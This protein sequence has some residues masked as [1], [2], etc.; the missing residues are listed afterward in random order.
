MLTAN[1]I[2]T[3]KNAAYRY[4]H[5]NAY[6]DFKVRP[7]GDSLGYILEAID[8]IQNHA[9]GFPLYFPVTCKVQDTLVIGGQPISAEDALKY[10]AQPGQGALS[11]KEDEYIKGGRTFPISLKFAP[12]AWLIGDFE[13]EVYKPVLSYSCSAY[14]R[15]AMATQ[16]TTIEGLKIVGKKSLANVS[17]A[18]NKQIGLLMTGGNNVHLTNCHFF[19]LDE[20]FVQN[21]TYHTQMTLMRFINCGRGYLSLGAE[22]SVGVNFLSDHCNIGYE[23]K[24]GVG[25]WL[26]VHTEQCPKGVII[27]ASVNGFIGMYLEQLDKTSGENDYQLQI[28]YESGGDV[29]NLSITAM[30]IAGEKGILMNPTAKGLTI[31][32]SNFV[33]S[34][35][36]TTSPDNQLSITNSFTD[37]QGAQQGEIFIDGKQIY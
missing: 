4:G 33:S 36:K 27:G 22:A 25:S 23:L 30:N 5:V 1:Q 32:G 28:G 35:V 6:Q 37:I 29:R 14:Q 7:E 26:G 9:D 19:G 3:R 34:E 21:C 11:Y 8:F 2:A 13:T 12:R 18:G 17:G 15:G 24:S 10:H 16:S 20:G 31:T